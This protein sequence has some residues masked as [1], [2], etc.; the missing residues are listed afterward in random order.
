MK[1]KDHKDEKDLKLVQFRDYITDLGLEAMRCSLRLQYHTWTVT[2]EP[3]W[4]SEKEPT[5]SIIWTV[6]FNKE[7]T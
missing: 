6:K 7:E 3:L 1:D 2:G 5:F 4:A